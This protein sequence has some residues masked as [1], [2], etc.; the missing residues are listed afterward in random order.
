MDVRVA[1]VEGLGRAAM[2]FTALPLEGAMLVDLEPI[3]DERGF[4]ARSWCPD[5]F[6]EHG[7][8]TR[9]AAS[10][11]SVNTSAGTL[12]GMHY[13]EPPHGEAKL[14]RCTAGAIYDVVVDLRPE[15]PTYCRWFAAE[16][17]ASNHSAL[18]APEGFA[19]GFQTLE[20]DSE[21]LYSMSAPYVAEAA[22]GVRWD[23][24]AFRIEWPEATRV[25]SARD[26]TFADYEP[27]VGA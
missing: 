4:F 19:H 14:V 16:L 6:A 8:P 3:A 18:F 12:R 22:R 20:P 27:R 25:I 13:Q 1:A 9:I 2:R 26:A 10:N 15:S 11:V 17:T 21:V 23:D 24:P 5:E 7:L